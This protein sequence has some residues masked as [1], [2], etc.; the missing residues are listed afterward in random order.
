MQ[1]ER[2]ARTLATWFG[3]GSSPIAPGTVGTLGALP[4]HLALRAMGPI[5]YAAAVAAVSAVGVWASQREAERLKTED[6]QS[7][8]IDE[9]AGVLLALLLA[10]G[11]G[12]KAEVAA[13][14]LFRVFDIAKPGPVDRV[15]HLSPEGVGIMADDL[16]AG[17]LAGVTA[18]WVGGLLG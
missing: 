7:V 14:V 4:L 18:R 3:C 12:W 2:L 13:V 5:P 10:R 17:I 1:R 16:L 11:A 6:P 15:Q 9:V 8:V